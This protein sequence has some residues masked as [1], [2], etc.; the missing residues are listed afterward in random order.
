MLFC[1]V[2]FS[3][4]CSDK[5]FTSLTFEDTIVNNELIPIEN[6]VDGRHYIYNENGYIDVFA[7]G[8]WYSNARPYQLRQDT[9]VFPLCDVGL[10]AEWI[11]EII[12]EHTLVINRIKYKL[13]F[14]N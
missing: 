1:V 13:L 4:S 7:E 12:D 8:R 11:Y 6:S 9:I 14:N 2:F 10:H 5:D 3:T